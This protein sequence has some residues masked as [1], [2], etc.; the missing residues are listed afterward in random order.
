MS[1]QEKN[2]ASCTISTADLFNF[3]NNQRKHNQQQPVENTT[4]ATRCTLRFNIDKQRGVDFSQDR[5]VVARS[6]LPVLE[7][8]INSQ[9]ELFLDGDLERLCHGIKGG[10]KPAAP[11]PQ[12][13]PAK[14][15]APAT[16]AKETEKRGLA[17]RI[18][19]IFGGE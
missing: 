19:G 6:D 7:Q 13:A 2:A 16:T 11:R 15:A 10:T 12:L 1:E 14:P 18:K 8:V 4:I 5:I 9:F 17:S 3:I